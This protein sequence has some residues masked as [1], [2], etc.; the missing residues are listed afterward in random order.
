MTRLVM[1][2]T[3]Y[4]IDQ[5]TYIQ[6]LYNQKPSN[7]TKLRSRI[8]RA[9]IVQLDACIWLT[10]HFLWNAETPKGL[11]YS[12]HFL[13]S[14]EYFLSFVNSWYDWS[15]RKITD[16]QI[17]RQKE[18][19]EKKIKIHR[20]KSTKTEKSTKSKTETNTIAADDWRLLIA[21]IPR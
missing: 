10:R 12:L 7:T 1:S 3:L 20:Q 14:K 4:L 19:Q 16:T 8:R 6:P 15:W 18:K 5:Q 13:T 17:E 11:L 21:R 9:R 2:D